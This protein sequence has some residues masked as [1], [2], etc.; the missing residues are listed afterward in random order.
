MEQLRL[1]GTLI[2][3]IRQETAI[4]PRWKCWRDSTPDPVKFSPVT[5]KTAH[6]IYQKAELLDRQ[7]HKPRMHGGVLGRA[8]LK[9]LH[10]LLFK[11][12]NFRTG[13]LDPSIERISEISGVCVRT[14]HTAL[15]KLSQIGVIAWE[16]RRIDVPQETGGNL[17]RQ[18]TNA[19]HLLPLQRWGPPEE[20]PAPP[21][22]RDTLG[23]PEA[24]PQP[25]ALALASLKS[26]S[27]SQ[28]Y[29]HLTS[30]PTDTLS[31]A[32]AELGRLM[33]RFSETAKPA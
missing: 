2:P 23:Y 11:F 21:P 5:R 14:V 16:R 8:T 6:N 22:T 7:T 17:W 32:L 12:H 15:Q 30:D 24:L 18:V 28:A 25:T 26:D 19:Y 33:G 29:Q 9:V 1:I 4:T 3:T 20:V 27:P 31:N 10:T 13:R